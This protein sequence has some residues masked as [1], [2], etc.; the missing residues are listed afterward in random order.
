MIAVTAVDGEIVVA[1]KADPEPGPGEI[2]VRVRGA[3]VN[4]ADLL[5]KAGLYPPPP[6]A[7]QDI[8]GMELAGEVVARGEGVSRFAAGN[9]VMAIVSGGAQ[10]ELCIV[11]EQ[12]AMDVPNSIDFVRAGGFPE[13]FTTAHDAL[14]TRC[15][16]QP[17]ERLLVHGAAGGVGT[18]AVQLGSALGADVTATVRDPDK[19]KGVS[20]LG[21]SAVLSPEDFAES[22]EDLEFDVI[23]ELVG[24]SNLGPDMAALAPHGR[25]VVIGI[26]AG[27]K[28][29]LNL[30][31][32]M[33]KYG[34]IYGSTLRG[35]SIEEKGRTARALER[36]VIP[37]LTAG[38][39]VVPI[40]AQYELKDAAKAYEH[41]AA[42]GKLGKI[43]ITS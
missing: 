41:F 29:E 43:V 5:Q 9:H 20:K 7:P 26:G 19:R 30:R 27:A 36:E 23:L 31:T 25:L 42:G 12:Q 6:D 16:L 22:A 4:G 13:V 2:L 28:G 18:A 40:T 15:R 17:A 10:A 14:V 21:A 32:L 39:I 37:L 38:E 33:M 8:L 1:E 11:P 34:S 24:A 3:G 35:R